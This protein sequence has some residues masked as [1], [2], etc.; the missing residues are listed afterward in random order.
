MSWNEREPFTLFGLT[1]DDEA[2]S[3]F[4]AEQAPHKVGKPSD[5]TQY[6]VSKDG[7]FELMFEDPD[8]RGGGK[9]AEPD[10]CRDLPLR[11]ACRWAFSVRRHLA[12]RVFL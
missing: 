5:G 2:V 4:L 7:G 9:Q 8:N 10:A 1:Y 11:R 6:I 3:R 12:S